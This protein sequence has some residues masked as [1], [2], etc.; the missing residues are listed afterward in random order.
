[1][2]SFTLQFGP[3]SATLCNFVSANK[4]S[5]ESLHGRTALHFA[6]HEGHSEVVS[7]LLRMLPTIMFLWPLPKPERNQSCLPPGSKNVRCAKGGSSTINKLF[8]GFPS[9]YCDVLS[10]LRAFYVFSSVSRRFLWFRHLSLLS[11]KEPW[12]KCNNP[13]LQIEIQKSAPN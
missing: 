11:Q 10:T 4:D 2:F 7:L 6:V 8:Y 5:T 12:V 1:M 13:R 3:P 9:V